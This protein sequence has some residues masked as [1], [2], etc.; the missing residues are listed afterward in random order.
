MNNSKINSQRGN[1]FLVILLGV[2]LFAALAYVVARGMRSETTTAMTHRQAELAASDILGYAARIERA[3]SKI[4]S[5]GASENDLDFGNDIVTGYDLSQP[6]K[7]KIFKSTGGGAAWKTPA[8]GVNDGSEWI[9][10]GETCVP[11]VGTG[12]AGCGGDSLSNEELL[13]VLPKI[14]ISICN[15][16]NK[17]LNV[18]GLPVSA[19]AP[20]A[21]KFAGAFADSVEIT[22]ADGLNAACIQNGSD[23]YFYYVLLVR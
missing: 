4:R 6:D 13:I 8:T 17:R 12:G 9:I 19:A 22:N 23:Y 20:S 1:V 5:R 18:A 14:K 3:V 2:A 7:N 10:T 11:G 21:T 15:E 16:I